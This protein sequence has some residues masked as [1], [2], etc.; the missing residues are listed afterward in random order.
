MQQQAVVVN[1]GPE[2]QNGRKAQ[3]T[4]ITTAKTVA[5]VIRTCLGPRAMLKMILDPMGGIL[6]TN[7]GNAILREIEVA[8]PAAKSMIE[9]SR[10]QDEEVG[11]G[12]TSVIILAGEILAQAL[13]YLERNIHPVVIISAFKRAL[14]EALIIIERI[15]VPVDPSNEKEMLALIKTSIGTKFVSR[16]SDMMCKL[17]LQAIR[18][19]AKTEDN[20]KST[21]DIK[22]YAKV[23]KVPGGEI[24]DS[25]VLD[26]VM[27]NKDVTHPK[28]RRRIENPRV[29][30]LDCPLEYKKGES[31]T[32]IEIQKEADWN[33]ILEI[34]EEQIKQMC[35]RIIEFKP[36]MVFTEKGVS[37]LAQHYLVKANITAIR[38]VRKSDNN[39]I[40]RATGATIVNRV[41]DLREIDIGTKCGLFN[42]EKLG[43][44]YFT[45]LT[46]CQDPKA[47]T[48]LL[49]GPSKDILHEIDRN[50][51]DAMAVARN[52]V[53]DP[54]LAPGGGATEM[55]ISVGLAQ[56][57][58]S[59]EGVEGWPFRAVSEAMEVIPRTLVQNCGGNAIRVLTSLRAKH[60]AGEHQFGVDGE[61]GKVVDMKEYGLYESAAVKV[62]TIKT[63][64]ESA[65]LLLRVDDI[66][67]AKR[68]QGENG[69]GVQSTAPGDDGEGGMQPEM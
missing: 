52:V 30:L 53:F 17:A 61:N 64:I 1:V 68:P 58:R 63:A 49:R 28:M 13:P 36:D 23:E 34:E 43:D 21:V 22:R 67:S 14:E 16:W 42:V 35:E 46:K 2:R 12:T 11:D 33:R 24:E 51:A 5:D 59:I 15:S 38:R 39:R 45:F 25:R 37:D 44:E 66:V 4:N 57:A 56:K 19:V 40:A 62:Q 31:Q 20:G 7:D 8:H 9:L 41:D 69:P 10:T 27:L 54:R 18:T 47:C 60:A 26:G 48:I 3:V 29:I 6:L 32:N 50:L 65:C 55:A